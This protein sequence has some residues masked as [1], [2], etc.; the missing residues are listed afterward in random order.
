MTDINNEDT[1]NL[2]GD[3]TKKEDLF[4]ITKY[5]NVGVL[6]AQ[7]KATKRYYKL[8]IDGS[9]NMPTDGVPTYEENHLLI[10]NK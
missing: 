3:I 4:I 1:A 2:T 10:L 7:S 8:Q 5:V 6:I 9:Y